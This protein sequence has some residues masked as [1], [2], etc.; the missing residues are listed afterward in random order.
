MTELVHLSPNLSAPK[1]TIQ[2]QYI[3]TCVDNTLVL[4]T[5]IANS[6]DHG[7]RS[8]AFSEYSNW[9]SAMQAV[10]RS[11]YSS[12]VSCTEKACADFCTTKGIQIDVGRL[13]TVEKINT[14]ITDH[15]DNKQIALRIEK[16]IRSFAGDKPTFLDHINAVIKNTNPIKGRAKIWRGYFTSLNTVRN[17]SSHSDPTLSNA[18]ADLLKANGFAALV[19]D[20]NELHTNTR[21]YI[22]ICRHILLFFE[23]VGA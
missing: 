20:T 23:E 12:I 21:N 3:G 2:A 9:H 22:Q 7:S 19:S 1:A 8:I 13:Q 18:E 4:L 14:L 17:K 15:I 16:Q 6:I 10:H 11:F 5:A